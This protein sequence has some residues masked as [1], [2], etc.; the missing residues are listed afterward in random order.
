MTGFHIDVFGE[1]WYRWTCGG[2]FLV[3]LWNNDKDRDIWELLV[4]L[5]G[6]KGVHGY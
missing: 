3:E 1:L 6:D 4:E 5:T 2:G